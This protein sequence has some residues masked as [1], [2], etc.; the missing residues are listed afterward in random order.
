M[1]LF[2]KVQHKYSPN[3]L[4]YVELLW[5][6]LTRFVVSFKKYF[7]PQSCVLR[8]PLLL[9]FSRKLS[10]YFP[11]SRLFSLC[12]CECISDVSS[13]FKQHAGLSLSLRHWAALPHRQ[14]SLHEDNP[15]PEVTHLLILSLPPFSRSC[16]TQ[17][18]A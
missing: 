6:N 18:T 13:R 7:I 5:S 8:L 16:R 12:V 15:E 4:P 10:L 14:R 11:M 2:S 17:M 9:R 3:C 1:H